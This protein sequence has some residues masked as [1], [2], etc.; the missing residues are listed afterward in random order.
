METHLLTLF[1]SQKCLVQDREAEG[2]RR[3]SNVENLVSV[4]E[5][6]VGKEY[7]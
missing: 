4:C 5:N 2:N 1:V 6:A 3:I 7:K